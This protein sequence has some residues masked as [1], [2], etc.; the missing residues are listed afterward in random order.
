MLIR[1]PR[2]AIHHQRMSTWIPQV[3]IDCDDN[4][5]SMIYGVVRLIADRV[6]EIDPWVT[7][8]LRKS[9]RPPGYAHRLT[10]TAQVSCDDVT[11]RGPVHTDRARAVAS[12]MAV[13]LW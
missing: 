10:L 6:T 9:S 1:R 4:D 7:L 11:P 3:C 8:V 2:W 13:Y 5:L 12:A